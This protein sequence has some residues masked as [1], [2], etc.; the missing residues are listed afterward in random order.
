MAIAR[1]IDVVSWLAVGAAA[2]LF[3]CHESRPTEGASDNAV[4]TGALLP[5]ASSSS[6][7]A[8]APHAAVVD[9]GAHDAAPPTLDVPQAS[10][11]EPRTPATAVPPAS[12][13]AAVTANNAFTASLFRQLGASSTGNLLTSPISASLALS[14]AYA[15]A[16][17][18]TAAEM[19][20][21]LQ[22]AGHA[23]IVLFE[24]QNALSQAL[25][26]RGAQ[27]F[28]IE[29]PKQRE[30]DAH[31]AQSDYALQI[32]NSLWGEASY[33]WQAP[34]TKTLATEY[35]AGLYAEDFR[36]HPDAARLKINAWVSVQTNDKINNLLP[37][38]AVGSA[39]R[40]LLVN[41]LHLKFPW[42]QP[43]DP[44][45]TKS[46]PFTRPDK[47][48]VSAAFMHRTAQFSYR[49]DGSAQIIALPLAGRQLSVVIALPHADVSLASYAHALSSGS[50]ALVEPEKSALVALALPKVA[51]TS[52]AI[53]LTSALQHLGINEA[54]DP[55]HAHFDAMWIKASDQ[56]NPFIGEVLQKTMIAI[57]ESGIEAAA[58]TAVVMMTASLHREAPK[59]PIAM[60]V[61]RPY[62][63]AIVD[64]PTGAVL[65]L[66]QINDPTDA[67]R[68]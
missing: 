36:G 15:G 45:A 52:A 5:A 43:F 33:Q 42:E 66:G 53:S 9:A 26:S 6:S 29:A 62:L 7:D 8:G 49:D 12:L 17:G 28:A 16:T 60:I 57:Q 48:Q 27:A 50:A 63:L 22:F 24:G 44:S 1:R 47:T 19:A 64:V 68:G 46:Q 25:V 2:A 10:A 35:G 32:V 51:F 55:Q 30:G 37:S 31:A 38:S 21:A 13:K 20:K 54:F 34:F 56:T 14:M 59:I 11:S 4:A 58:A 67:G 65:M 3:G 18:R 40:L 23:P 39:T 41:A 61:N